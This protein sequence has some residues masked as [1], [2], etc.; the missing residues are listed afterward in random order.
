MQ[1]VGG[2]LRLNTHCIETALNFYKM[3]LSRGLTRGRPA[4]HT[5]ASCLYITCRL[6]GTPHFLLDFSDILQV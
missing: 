5:I 3:A 2:Q 4:S 1:E 6:E